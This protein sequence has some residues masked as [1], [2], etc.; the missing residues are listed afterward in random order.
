MKKGPQ[1]K[2]GAQNNVRQTK[3]CYE[4]NN[5]VKHR[6]YRLTRMIQRIT[7]PSEPFTFQGTVNRIG[8]LTIGK[9][10]QLLDRKNERTIIKP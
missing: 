9:D 1:I 5:R 7:K 10:I 4:E 2:K 3:R 8:A 6:K